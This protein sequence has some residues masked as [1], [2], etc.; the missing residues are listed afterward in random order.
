MSKPCRTCKNFGIAD[1]RGPVLLTICLIVP[2]GEQAY[3]D[4]EQT[5]EKW[6]AKDELR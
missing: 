1:I 6:E 5:C 4:E 3:R 2:V